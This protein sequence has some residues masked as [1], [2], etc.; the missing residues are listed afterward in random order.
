MHKKQV[1]VARGPGIGG[2]EEG[3]EHLGYN[4]HCSCKVCQHHL[5][6]LKYK[7]QFEPHDMELNDKHL[8]RRFVEEEL[9]RDGKP[10]RTAR[11]I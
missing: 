1:C 9:D 7:E 4:F 5:D 8:F 11:A 6:K 3:G 10:S 2:L